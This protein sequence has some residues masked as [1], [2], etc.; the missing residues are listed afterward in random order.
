MYAHIHTHTNKHNFYQTEPQSDR[1]T[2]EKPYNNGD[3]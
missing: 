2:K 1:T 3:G